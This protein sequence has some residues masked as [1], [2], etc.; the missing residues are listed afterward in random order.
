MSGEGPEAFTT[1]EQLQSGWRSL[2]NPELTYAA[3]LLTAAG[4]WIRDQYLEAKG[5]AIADNN[6]AALTVSIDV[7]KTAMM[8]A[9][10]QGHISYNRVEGSRQKA[11][12]LVNPGGALSFSDW[13]KEQL[14]I[15][16]STLGIGIFEDC[17]D[18]RY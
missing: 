8:T 18:A 4:K 1:A 15:P 14:G 6:P 17:P 13:H 3:Q 16:T 10:Y 9:A 7:V 11:G 5:V 12:T 2:S